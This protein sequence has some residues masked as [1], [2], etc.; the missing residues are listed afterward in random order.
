MPKDSADGALP[1]LHSV[2]SKVWL[3]DANEGWVTGEVT[4]ITDGTKL[5]VLMEDGSERICTQDEIPLQNPGV[6]GVEVRVGWE[7]LL[8][9]T[10]H[11][12]E[13]LTST[14]HHGVGH[15]NP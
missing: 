10:V 7:N 6:R 5:S 4:R 2:G 14:P 1:A 13:S 3:A 15:D 12:Y 9:S 8:Q 11:L